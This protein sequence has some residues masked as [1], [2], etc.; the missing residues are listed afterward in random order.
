[1]TKADGS[2]IIEVKLD[3]SGAEKVLNGLNKETDK[4]ADAFDD[5]KDASKDAEKAAFSFGDAVKA[6]VLSNAIVS[7]FGMLTDAVKGFASGMVETAADLR[8]EASQFTQTFGEMEWTATDVISGIAN[9]T[10][11]LETRL[12]SAAT[13]IYAFARSSGGSDLESMDLME[14]ALTAAADAA[15]YYDRSLDET[16][17]QLMSFLKG[18]YENDAAL[19]LSATETTRNAAAMEQFGKEFNDL[20]EIQKQQ[21]LLKMVQDAQELS[22]AMGQ[23]SRESDG[24]ENVMGNLNEVGRQIQGNIGAPILEAIIPAM[25]EITN[26]LMQWSEGMDWD[27]FGDAVGG[28]VTGMIDNGP[29][30]ISLIAGI[31]AGFVAWNVVSTIQGVVA[32]ITAFRKANEGATIAQ[33]AMNAAMNANPIGIVITA[34]TAL[35]AIIGTL[36]ATNEDFRNAVMEIWENIKQAFLDAWEAIKG[37]WDQAAGFFTDIWESIKTTFSEVQAALGGFFTDAWSTIQGVWNAATGFFSSIWE[38]I[39][40]I[41]SVVKSTLSGFFDDAWNAVQ[42]VFSDWSEFFSGL[43]DDLTSIFDQAW[44]FFSGIG[45]DIVDGIKNGISNAWEGLKNWFNGLWNGLFGNRKA[46]VTVEKRAVD[47]A[48][49][50][51][52]G[53]VSAS[54]MI[55]DAPRL[56]TGSVIPPNRE[57]LAVL[58]DNT[59]ETEVVS[60]VSTMKQAFIEAMREMGMGDG[61]FNFTVNLDGKTVAKNTV[62]H[63]NNMTRQ[64]GK[65]VLLF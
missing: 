62:K 4:V 16:T 59:R 40:G 64:A 2:I 41:F 61:T 23:A 33:L 25:Q 9:E 55:A 39:K 30:I 34:I 19:G 45:S 10:G 48:T 18:N 54:R 31:A 20:T 1:M 14:G 3:T 60:P 15:A 46:S 29:T 22:G 6:N 51:S 38:E 5:V 49:S 8:A 36:W 50:R 12:N 24:L 63:I 44:D 11:I 43:W 17:D 13:S 42:G 35:I 26:S 47:A 21:T 57:F 28:F 7:G 37:A 32:A 58:G 56:A 53:L 52:A 65:P 27:A